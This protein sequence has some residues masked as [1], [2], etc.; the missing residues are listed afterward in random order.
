ML[1]GL[2]P[3][4]QSSVFGVESALKYLLLSAFSSGML[5]FGFS[6]YYLRTGLSSFDHGLADMSALTNVECFLMLL[7]LL[8]KLGAA[9]LHLWYVDIHQSLQKPLLMYL[10]TAPKLSLFCFWAS[11]WQHIWT[12]FSVGVF[13][14]FSMLLG[15]L[16]AYGQPALRGLFAYGAI[17]EIGLMLLAIEAAGFHTLIQHLIIYA[18]TQLLLWSLIDKRLFALCAISFAG[19]PPLAG[20]FG[21]LFIFWHAINAHLFALVAVSLLC[22]GVSLVYYLRV[23]RL[24]WSSGLSPISGKPIGQQLV[25]YNGVASVLPQNT[26]V[27][28]LT[29]SNAELTSALAVSLGFLPL[30]FIK[31][32]V[33]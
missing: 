29:S 15:S 16:G 30:F 10:S 22:T 18:I 19:L 9:P 1:C 21:K 33:L 4:K 2:Q 31:P 3:S 6:V 7:A 27:N 32:F 17:N 26:G 20:F 14:C 8:F 12:D 25:H 28:S 11:A 5:L 13:V 24:F 23:L